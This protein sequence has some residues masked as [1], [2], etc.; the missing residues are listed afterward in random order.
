MAAAELARSRGA[1]TI[2]FAGKAD[3]PLGKTVDYVFANDA[4]FGVTDSKLIML[5]QIVFCLLDKLGYGID[6]EQVQKELSPKPQAG[7]L[8][9]DQDSFF[10]F[11]AALGGDEFKVSSI[12]TLMRLILDK[13]LSTCGLG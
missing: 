8:T 10:T 6:Y 11:S 4:P 5:Y 13:A 1:R 12:H 9:C 2:A 3:T 7:F